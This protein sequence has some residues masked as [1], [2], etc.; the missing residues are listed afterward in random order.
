MASTNNNLQMLTLNEYLNVSYI[1]GL[2]VIVL[3]L[4]AFGGVNFQ[5]TLGPTE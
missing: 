3:L 5:Q 2:C 1:S 4:A